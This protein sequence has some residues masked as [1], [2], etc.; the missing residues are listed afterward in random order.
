MLLKS[1]AST[2]PCGKG[3][4][5]CKVSCPAQALY[6]HAANFVHILVDTG[7]QFYLQLTPRPPSTSN[8][9]PVIYSASS[10]ARKHTMFATSA[11]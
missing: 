10:D 9:A 1:S 8:A 7:F 5:A 6:N 4:S 3:R 11:G 2:T